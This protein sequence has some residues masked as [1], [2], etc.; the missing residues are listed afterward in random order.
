MEKEVEQPI[1]KVCVCMDWGC[2]CE[3]WDDSKSRG[4]W[5]RCSLVATRLEKMLECV[6]ALE[7]P[8]GGE[9]NEQVAGVAYRNLVERLD[10]PREKALGYLEI[11]TKKT[12]GMQLFQMGGKGKK[13]KLRY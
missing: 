13:T 8:N 7:R 5:R 9:D 3:N 2:I 4:G 6:R 10:A 12:K 11:A 1:D